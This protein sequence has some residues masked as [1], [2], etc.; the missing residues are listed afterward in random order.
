M[1]GRADI[2][3]PGI[4]ILKCFMRKFGFD[5]VKVSTKGLRYG[6]FLRDVLNS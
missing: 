3:I 4:L 6:V 1:T 5:N 2:V